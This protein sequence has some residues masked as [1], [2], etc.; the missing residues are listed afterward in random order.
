M[1]FESYTVHTCVF[2]VNSS[3]IKLLFFNEKSLVLKLETFSLKFVIFGTDSIEGLARSV[4]HSHHQQLIF[5]LQRLSCD[6]VFFLK[7]LEPL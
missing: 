6:A 1:Y 4:S 3:L 2:C 7:K 5:K